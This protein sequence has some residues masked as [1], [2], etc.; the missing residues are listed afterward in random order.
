MNAISQVNEYNDT[1]MRAA[2]KKQQDA[3]MEEGAV[4]VA[5]RQDRIDRT[6]A[7]IKENQ[8]ALIEAS[9]ADFGNRAAHLTQMADIMAT[10]NGLKH[11][12]DHV[13]KWAQP[14]KRK[15]AFPMNILGAKAQVEYQPKGVIGNIATWNFPTHVALAPL[16]GIFA[17]GN[18]CMIKMSELTPQVS[19]LLEQ[20]IAKYF[21]E[22][23]LLAVN[24]GP[25]IGAAFAA[26]PFDHILFTGAT[27]IGRHIL[28]AAADNL[29]P[30]TLEL[31]G[32]SPVIISRSADIEKT[33]NRIMAGKA[34]NIGQ[35]CLSPDYCF[36]AEEQRDA[37]VDAM[38]KRFSEM[39][40]TIID[41]P[42]Y[43]SVV[44][45]RHLDRLQSYIA[46]AREKGADVREINPANEDMSTQQGT[47][48]M[49]LH[50]VVDPTDDML[51]MQEE[52]FGAIICVKSYKDINDAIRYVNSRPRPLALYYFGEDKAEER[53]VLD[54]TISGGVALNDVMA[55]TGC[56]NLPFGGV[57]ASGMG[58][59]H[60]HAG[61]LTFS[62]EK[63]VYRQTKVDLT[64]LAG[65]NPPYTDKCRAQL[66]K[67]T[68][69]K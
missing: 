40:P 42:D 51:V 66:D 30:V 26:L 49:P 32:K 12:R 11:A 56:E 53:K 9:S 33:A 22:T 31:G 23:E 8:D 62:H 37:L 29:T 46:D 24:G 41:N 1:T 38:V 60:G 7:L 16:A 59:Y 4:S 17:A 36:V 3:F 28:H 20:L 27:G 68:D 43:T 5:T 65:M 57:G 67:L 19:G 18:R 45:A 61:F 39:F 47:H 63:A 10:L 25:D 69:R 55:H 2:L 6:I 58:N 34:M 64:E 13:A 52:L 44:N 15:V 50:I 14:S 35:V 54:K 48:K 21:D